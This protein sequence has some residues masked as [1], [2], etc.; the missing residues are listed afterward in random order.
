MFSTCVVEVSWRP[1]P[2]QRR[3]PGAGDLDED[4]QQRRVAGAPDEARPHDHGLQPGAVGLD[5]RRLGLRP[6]WRRTAPGESSASGVRSSAATSGWPCISAASVPTCTSRLTPAAR[7]AAITALVPSTLTRRNSSQGPK[8]PSRAAAWKA[9]SAP[10]APRSSAPASPRSPRDGLRAR[11]RAPSP[12]PR[13]SGRARA[14]SSRRRRGGGS[15]RR[16]RS[17]SRPSRT[18]RARRATIL[19]CDERDPRAGP[20]PRA[21]GALGVAAVVGRRLRASRWSCSARSAARCP[22]RGR[23]SAWRCSAVALAGRHAA[24]ARAALAA[25]A[26]GGARARDRPPAR[27][28]RRAAH[29]DP[30]GARAARRDGARA[31]RPGARARDGRD[32]HRRRQPR[33]PAAARRRR[34]AR[35]PRAAIA[36][37]RRRTDDG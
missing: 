9:T 4:R 18:R 31:D 28:P 19:R 20:A 37:A 35:M 15:G 6:W 10:R 17:R 5:H 32:P 7:Q 24:G 3:R 25:L 12:P 21:P 8:S 22:G 23:R 1:P 29:A 30:D 14:R 34:A 27:D 33:D 16:R 2:I 13:G 11:P 36:G 26:L